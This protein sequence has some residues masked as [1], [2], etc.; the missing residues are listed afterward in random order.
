MFKTISKNIILFAAV[1][2]MLTSC[3]AM[4]KQGAG[5]LM[6]TVAGAAI[7]AQF[8]KGSGKVLAAGLGAVAG[9][10]LGSSIGASLDEK[11]K[12]MAESSTQVALENVQSGKTTSWKNPDSGHSG[13]ITPIKTFED[14]KGTYCREFVQK[15]YIGGREQEAYGTACR[16]PDG[17]WEMISSGR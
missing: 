5:G 3:V 13:S 9:G 17:S 1:G 11:D 8:G 4:N 16:R 10:L 14:K 6:G 12:K 2:T 15:V 7:G